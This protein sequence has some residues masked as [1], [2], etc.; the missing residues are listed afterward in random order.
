MKTT[1]TEV[2]PHPMPEQKRSSGSERERISVSLTSRTSA[3]LDTIIARSGGGKSEA[4]NRAISVYAFTE[5]MKEE[6]RT[7]MVRAA[8][9][10][11]YQVEIV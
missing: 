4:V 11:L 6:N 2:E 5:R 7:L 1:H 8:D 9:G 3:E 10:A